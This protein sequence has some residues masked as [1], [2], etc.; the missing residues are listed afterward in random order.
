MT[1]IAMC[2]DKGKG[3]R[4]ACFWQREDTQISIQDKKSCRCSAKIPQ[5]NDAESTASPDRLIT[6]ASLAIILCSWPSSTAALQKRPSCISP[7]MPCITRMTRWF[8]I[9]FHKFINVHYY[10]TFK[11]FAHVVE[12]FLHRREFDCLIIINIL[13]VQNFQILICPLSRSEYITYVSF[14]IYVSPKGR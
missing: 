7:N 5:Q 6:L 11:A 14:K 2:D 3:C 4:R 1:A 8:S 10:F 9:M 13:F 12:L